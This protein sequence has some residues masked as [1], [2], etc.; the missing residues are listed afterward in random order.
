[1][2]LPLLGILAAAGAIGKVAGGLG[3]GRADGRAAEADINYKR[4]NQQLD[5]YATQQRSILDAAQAMAS[6]NKTDAQMG[7]D[8]PTARGKQALLGDALANYQYKAPTH[9]RANVVDFGS[10]FNLSANTRE[11]G[12]ML[13][14]GALNDQKQGNSPLSKVDF[15]SALIAPPNQTALPQSSWLDK[16]LNA[17]GTV[18]TIAGGVGEAANAFGG[19]KSTAKSIADFV[20]VETGVPSGFGT[21]VSFSSPQFRTGRIPKVRY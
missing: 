8:A 20:P 18:G 1:M 13:S 14:A 6:Q 17:A 12:G 19:E 16:L 15:Q 11:L 2:P 4:D 5:R 3:K 9:A 10:P 7:L 21:P